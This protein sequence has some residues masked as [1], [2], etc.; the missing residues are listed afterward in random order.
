MQ[1]YSIQN[2]IGKGS[3]A[4]VYKGIHLKTSHLVAIKTVTLRKL[5]RKLYENLETEIQI[6]N[7]SRHPNVVSLYNVIK[8]KDEI[9]MVM[10]FCVL[11]DLSLFIKKKAI[12]QEGEKVFYGGPWGGLN[13]FVFRYLLGQLASAIEFLRSLQIT[14][15]DL[16]PQVFGIN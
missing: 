10:E 6:L 13:E 12:I 5:N 14:H 11:G 3:F 1:E 4:T 2:E 9:N 15:R 16:K 7:K 8:T